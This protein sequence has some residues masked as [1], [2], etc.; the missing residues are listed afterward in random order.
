MKK[1]SR[2]LVATTDVWKPRPQLSADNS[3][4]NMLAKTA[5]ILNEEHRTTLF[6][7]TDKR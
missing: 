6:S 2:T 7:S 3:R 1:K 4:Y 5:R